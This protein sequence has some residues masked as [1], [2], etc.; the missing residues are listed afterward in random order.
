MTVDGD[1]ENLGEPPNAGSR[2]NLPSATPTQKISG[3]QGSQTLT[4]TPAPQQKWQPALV[5]RRTYGDGLLDLQVPE[6][7]VKTQ[8]LYKGWQE[9]VSNATRSE[10]TRVS[11]NR[12]QRQAILLRRRRNRELLEAC[13]HQPSPMQHVEVRELVSFHY[14]FGVAGGGGSIGDFVPPRVVYRL[15]AR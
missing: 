3:S 2:M 15:L 7:D 12:A 13:A 1:A 11:R 9:K 5:L 4:R 8:N 10:L 6:G 14:A